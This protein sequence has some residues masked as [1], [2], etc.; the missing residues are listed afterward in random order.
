MQVVSEAKSIV[1]ITDISQGISLNEGQEVMGIINPKKS[2]I[3]EDDDMF[4]GYVFT[5]KGRKS[6]R[7]KFV[8]RLTQRLKWIEFYKKHY[9]P[10]FKIVKN[11]VQ[12]TKSIVFL[13][14]D[15]VFLIDTSGSMKQNTQIGAIKRTIKNFVASKGKKVSVA[16]VA[17]NGH[18]TFSEN[19]NATVLLNFTNDKEKIMS[20]IDTLQ[21]TNLNTMYTSG[22]KKVY[23]LFKDRKAKDKFVFLVSDGVDSG[24]NNIQS[25]KKSLEQLGVK[26]KPIAVGG[27]SMATLK[28][29]SS[30]GN[31]YDVTSSDIGTL[32]VENVNAQDPLFEKLAA[33]NSIFTK[34][35]SNK[36]VMIIYS[37]MMEKSGLYDFYMVPN[38]TDPLF[39]KEVNRKLKNEGLNIDFGGYNVYVRLIG[40][41]S[42]KKENKLKLFWK[43]FIEEHNGKVKYFSKDPLEVSD[44]VSE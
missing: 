23:A 37:T 32:V 2:S 9:V 28:K 4:Y 10:Y 21:F 43:R 16:I 12:K 1:A 15:V 3:F 6:T 39:Y 44:I 19:D 11:A 8:A 18:K 42:A 35:K 31:V 20:A 30:N 22:L 7:G 25:V 33:L 27:A 13:P 17:F 38:L 26:I 41:P 36:S 34:N 40:N 29:F 24:D 5:E 14:K